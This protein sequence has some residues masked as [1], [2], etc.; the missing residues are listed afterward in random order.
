MY[1]LLI[2]D[3]EKWIREGLRYT[4]NWEELDISEI[5]EAE[6]GGEAFEKVQEFSPDI[7]IT[8]IRMPD[9]D[10]LILSSMV[11]EKYPKTKIII[12]SGYQDFDYTKQA[13]SLGVSDYILKPIN[14][15]EILE[16]VKKCINAIEKEGLRQKEHEDLKT[17]VNEGIKNDGIRKIIQE[18]IDY[19]EQHYNRKIS[20]T[21]AAEHVYLNPSY[22]SKLFCEELGEP[23]TRFLMRVRINKAKDML[24]DPRVKVYEVAERVG[25]N[26]IKYFIKVFKDIEGS[27]PTDYRENN[28]PNK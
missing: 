20:L 22:L 5:I 15:N 13:I 8:D 2:V 6:D 27:T 12:I 28:M 24:K 23:F 9:F 26:D 11:R 21:T 14:E 16:T 19:V 10:G 4:I 3:D 17:Q 1:R 18:V 25:Y 7:I